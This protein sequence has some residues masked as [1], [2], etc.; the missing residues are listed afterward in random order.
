M[1]VKR[2]DIDGLMAGVISIHEHGDSGFVQEPINK[3]KPHPSVYFKGLFLTQ[4]DTHYSENNQIAD[5][6][7]VSQHHFS[8]FL[9]Q[10]MDVTNSLAQK[11]VTATGMPKDFWL[12]A[13][14]HYDS[15]N[16]VD[17]DNVK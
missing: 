13:Q 1:T 17:K 9:E 8:H 5:A 3:Q 6:L 10:Q 14:H 15:S 16:D 4:V 12:R 2:L 7:E 11:L